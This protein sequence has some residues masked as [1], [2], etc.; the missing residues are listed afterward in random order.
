[1]TLNNGI[2]ITWLGHSTFRIDYDGQVLLIDPFLT[3][4]PECPEEDKTFDRLDTLL[5]THGH[6]DHFADAVSLCLAHQPTVVCIYEIYQYLEAKG[7][8]NFSPMNKGG[9]VEVNGLRVTMTHAFHSSTITEE[10]G[11]MIP[12]GEAAGFVVEFPNGYSIYHA[13]DTGVFGDM[14]L[15][16]EMYRPDL[17][18]LPI[19]DRFTMGPRE[20]ARAIEL[21]GV[22]AVI[23]IHHGTFDMLTGT[24]EQLA[25]ATAGMDVE[26]ITLEPGECLA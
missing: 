5:I 15:I 25:S 1:M 12:A 3:P 4:N 18:L 21:I 7:A 22:E 11:T 2:R 9:A 23:P 16:G 8:Q 19:G 14:R 6:Q 13:G 10:D 17:A 24:P 20:A 26:I